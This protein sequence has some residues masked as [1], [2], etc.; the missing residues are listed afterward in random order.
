MGMG[1]KETQ[2][3]DRR[4]A[5]L[6]AFDSMTD[7][8]QCAALGM[9]QSIARGSPRRPSTVLKLVASSSKGLHLIGASGRV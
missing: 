7:E 5:L 6:A 8:A 3:M 9:L 1:Q 4:T 2:Q